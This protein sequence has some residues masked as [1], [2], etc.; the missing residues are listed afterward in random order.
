MAATSMNWVG[1]V[2]EPEAREMVTTP[3]SDG[4]LNLLLCLA[5]PRTK[6]KLFLRWNVLSLLTDIDSAGIVL[7]MK[8]KKLA[9]WPSGNGIWEQEGNY[10]ANDYQYPPGQ[11]P[12]SRSEVQERIL[13]FGYQILHYSVVVDDLLKL[14]IPSKEAEEMIS[15]LDKMWINRSAKYSLHNPRGPYMAKPSP[16]VIVAPLAPLTTELNLV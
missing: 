2:T 6:L 9:T 5:L 11:V 16:L 1:K 4:T 15:K 13:K 8:M 3:S 10:F 14:G 7:D 12:I